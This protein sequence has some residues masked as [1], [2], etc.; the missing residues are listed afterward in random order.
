MRHI[1]FSEAALDEEEEDICSA[2]VGAVHQAVLDNNLEK[3]ETLIEVLRIQLSQIWPHVLQDDFPLD[4]RD[5]HSLTPLHL[6][7]SLGRTDLARALLG[8]GASPSSRFSNKSNLN[9]V[10]TLTPELAPHTSPRFTWRPPAPTLRSWSCWSRGARP[11]ET[12][13]TGAGQ[14]STRPQPLVTRRVSVSV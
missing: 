1:P 5:V 2:G 4:E 11:G 14:F 8:G 9:K 6:A 10:L 12:E 13:T 7:V 3:L